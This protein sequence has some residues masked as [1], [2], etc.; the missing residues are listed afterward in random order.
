MA[1]RSQSIVV[2]N[3]QVLRDTVAP[4]VLIEHGFHTNE[5]DTALLKDSQYRQALASAEALGILDHLGL[6]LPA[7]PAEGAPDKAAEWADEA[8]ELAYKLGILD[9]TRPED[10]VTR[11]ELGVVLKRLGLL[12]KMME[13]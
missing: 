7:E 11:Q 1:V 8:W 2:D 4:A 13:V 6:S 12:D 9:G 3:I 5:Q 10:P